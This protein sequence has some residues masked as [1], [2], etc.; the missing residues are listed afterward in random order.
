MSCTVICI[1]TICWGRKFSQ[2]SSPPPASTATTGRCAKTL[3]RLG[4]NS[5][6]NTLDKCHYVKYDKRPTLNLNKTAMKNENHPHNTS[7]KRS[8]YYL[9]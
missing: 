4:A 8:T 3:T 1:L 6:L 5:C 7:T 2:E 9:K